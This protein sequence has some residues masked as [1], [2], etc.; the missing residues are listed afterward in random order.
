MALQVPVAE[1]RPATWTPQSTSVFVV[2]M[3]HFQDGD[4]PW[5]PQ[6]RFDYDLMALFKARGVPAERAVM[7][8]DEAAAVP[9]Y[10]AASWPSSRP[11]SGR[12]FSP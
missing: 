9:P 4:S 5:G 7:I 2:S 6:G 1:A 3:T 12:A 10:S 11:R 8:G